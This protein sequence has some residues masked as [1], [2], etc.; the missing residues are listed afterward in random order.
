MGFVMRV[1]LLKKNRFI[2]WKKREKELIKLC[3]KF[4]NNSS[5][6]DCVVPGSGGKDSFYAA[7][8][9]KYKY[10]MNPLTITWAPNMYTEWG[11]KTFNLGFMLVSTIY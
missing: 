4:R 3:D 1:I 7:H 10:G 11:L 2:N 5:G 8:V 9:L 6:Y